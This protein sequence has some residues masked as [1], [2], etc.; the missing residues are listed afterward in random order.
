MEAFDRRRASEDTINERM[1]EINTEIAPDLADPEVIVVV[2]DEVRLEHEALTKRAWY[3]RG[4]KTKLTVDRERKAQSYIGFLDQN[5]G[6]VHLETVQWQNSDTIISALTSFVLHH[7]GRKITIL[8]DNAGWHTS[9]KL[10]EQLAT[11]HTL[12][13]IH[14]I[15][16]PPLRARPQSHR[17]HLGRSQD[18]DLQPSTRHIHPNPHRV[19]NIHH[20][21]QVPLQTVKT[22]S[23]HG[24]TGSSQSRG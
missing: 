14:L 3:K 16:T 5:T 12:A 10:R 20:P 4:T 21:K 15:N 24:I 22:R 2:A 1:E 17:T 11:N 7:K 23:V 9:K 19:R 18:P 8:W 13:G 6:S